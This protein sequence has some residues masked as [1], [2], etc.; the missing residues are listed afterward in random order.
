MNQQ[1]Q[2][3]PRVLLHVEGAA[4]LITALVLYAQSGLSWWCFALLLFAPDLSMIGYLINTR[5]GAYVYNFFHLKALAVLLIVAGYIGIAPVIAAAG[6]LLLGH[7]CMDRAFGYGLKYT[8]GFKD[9]HL[10]VIGRGN[11]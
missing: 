4:V 7:S 8:T 9:T 2:K 10:G 5:V 11:E 6:W 3:M 1:L